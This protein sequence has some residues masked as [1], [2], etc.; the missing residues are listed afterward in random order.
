[1]FGES[2]KKARTECDLSQSEL[3]ARLSVSQ[4]TVG[5]WE[6]N[7]TSPPPETIAQIA[8]VLG[9]TTDYLL[10]SEKSIPQKKPEL[11]KKNKLI[12]EVVEMLA[13][14][15]EEKAELARNVVRAVV[16]P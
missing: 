11:T 12:N 16:E 5:S 7:R 3:A 8:V 2:L 6:V 10:S 1:M 9:V 4:Q 14:A 15:S 13:G